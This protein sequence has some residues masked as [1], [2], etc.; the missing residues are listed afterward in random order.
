MNTLTNFMIPINHLETDEYNCLRT[1]QRH[2]DNYVSY[3]KLVPDV[4]YVNSNFLPVIGRL[5]TRLIELNNGVE[6]VEYLNSIQIN[7]VQSDE[8]D[9]EFLELENRNEIIKQIVGSYNTYIYLVVLARDVDGQWKKLNDIQ[10]YNYDDDIPTNPFI[11]P[12]HVDLVRLI[13]P[14]LVQAS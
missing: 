12:L 3:F 9:Y 6:F 5:K 13:N 8:F 10:N 7:E 2:F 11:K 4:L 1:L 14:A